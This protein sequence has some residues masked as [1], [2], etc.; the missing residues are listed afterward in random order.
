MTDSKNKPTSPPKK[1]VPVTNKNTMRHT[2]IPSLLH[3]TKII[4]FSEETET[5]V[6]S[7]DI[8]L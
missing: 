3:I 5:G 4:K 6:L 1:L 7:N 8:L 2:D